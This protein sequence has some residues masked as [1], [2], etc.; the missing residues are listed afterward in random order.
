MSFFALLGLLATAAIIIAVVNEIVPY[1]RASQLHRYLHTRHGKP[2]W[3]MVTGAS[4][5]IGRALSN[6]LAANG[7]NIVLHGRNPS[8][9]TRVEQELLAAYPTRHFRILIADATQCAPDVFKGIV[10][11]V[12]D[13]HLTVLISNAG[14]APTAT[15]NPFKTLDGNTNKELADTLHLNATFPTMLLNALIP[16]LARDGPALIIVVGSL[17]AWGLPLVSAYGAT[18]AYL[19]SLCQSVAREM[20]IKERDVEVMYLGVGSVTGVSHTSGAPSFF[21]PSASTLAKGALARVGCRRAVIVPYWPHALQR[22][23]MDLMPGMVKDVI[24]SKTMLE[25]Q[26]KGLDPRERGGKSE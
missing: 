19:L 5:G 21:Q 17:A 11:Q 22:A 20:R 18:K 23:L 6:E 3:A 2:A 7:F 16:T 25:L 15:A 26:A 14:G 9:L 13:L 8:K 10:N 1:L 4:D 24:F 12:A